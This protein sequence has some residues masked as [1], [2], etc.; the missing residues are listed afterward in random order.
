MEDADNAMV[1]KE[2]GPSVLSTFDVDA[3]IAKGQLLVSS[4]SGVSVSF[5]AHPNLA[6]KQ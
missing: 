5:T 6:P 4:V 1:K 3:I 2:P